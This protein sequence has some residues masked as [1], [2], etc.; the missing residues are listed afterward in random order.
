MLL[1][2]E[3]FL[4]MGQKAVSGLRA[5]VFSYESISRH[6]F[7]SWQKKQGKYW[8]MITLNKC[9]RISLLVIQCKYETKPW[10]PLLAVH[11]AC[12]T[13]LLHSAVLTM[14][15]AWCPENGRS[16]QHMCLILWTHSKD[17]IGY[18]VNGGGGVNLH[19]KV[20]SQLGSETHVPTCPV[21]IPIYS[22]L[23]RCICL[24]YQNVIFKLKKK[25]FSF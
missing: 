23:R 20:T 7:K 10:L 19:S 22:A 24:H 2:H 12:T 5:S 4:E 13:V 3:F 15:R 16:S 18:L 6:Y 14:E 9:P 1:P 21:C 8:T 11:V 17:P 25:D